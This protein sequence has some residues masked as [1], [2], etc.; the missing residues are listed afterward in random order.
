MNVKSLFSK[1]LFVLLIVIGLFS[2][3]GTSVFALDIGGNDENDLEYTILKWRRTQDANYNPE[4]FYNKDILCS[5]STMSSNVIDDTMDGVTADALKCNSEDP[6]IHKYPV[7]KMLDRAQPYVHPDHVNEKHSSFSMI[8][9]LFNVPGRESAGWKEYTGQDVRD[10]S[11]KLC[12]RDKNKKVVYSNCADCTPGDGVVDQWDAVTEGYTSGDIKYA[13]VYLHRMSKGFD[14]Y[15]NFRTDEVYDGSGSTNLDNVKK[16]SMAYYLTDN[17]GAFRVTNTILYY[18][19]VPHVLGSEGSKTMIMAI[20]DEGTGRPV[21]VKADNNMTGFSSVRTS[22][23][24][25]YTEDEIAG[26]LQGTDKDG[27]RYFPYYGDDL[28][29]DYTTIKDTMSTSWYKYHGFSYY[30]SE[31]GTTKSTAI[32]T[33]AGLHAA[34]TAAGGPQY[35]G[36]VEIALNEAITQRNSAYAFMSSYGTNGG[37]YHT[38]W[39]NTHGNNLYPETTR[40]QYWLSP[41]GTYYYLNGNTSGSESSINIIK[42]RMRSNI[43]D[44]AYWN[45]GLSGNVNPNG[46]NRNFKHSFGTFTRGACYSIDGKNC[47]SR[48]MFNY[49]ND[50]ELHVKNINGKSYFVYELVPKTATCDTVSG[51]TKYKK[52][53]ST[54]K[55]GQK[56]YCTLK[57]NNGISTFY[58]SEGLDSKSLT[59]SD[60]QVAHESG[61]YS[62]TEYTFSKI[63]IDKNVANKGKFQYS[64]AGN[65]WG[66][67][68]Q[69]GWSLSGVEMGGGFAP[70]TRPFPQSPDEVQTDYSDF[71]NM[72]RFA[73]SEGYYYNNES[74][75]NLGYIDTYIAKSNGTE[76]RYNQYEELTDMYLTIIRTFPDMIFRTFEFADHVKKGTNNCTAAYP[77]PNAGSGSGAEEE[78]IEEYIKFRAPK[79]DYDKIAAKL[80]DNLELNCNSVATFKTA[81]KNASGDTLKSDLFANGYLAIVDALRTKDSGN[82]TYAE[83]MAYAFYNFYVVI[84]MPDEYSVGMIFA[85]RNN[86]RNYNF[87]DVLLGDKSNIIMLNEET[88]LGTSAT[89]NV[90]SKGNSVGTNLSSLGSETGGFMTLGEKFGPELYLIN[91]TTGEVYIPEMD[92]ESMTCPTGYI[93]EDN[94]CKAIHVV[95][96]NR[97][98][99]SGYVFDFNEFKCVE[100]G[101]GVTHCPDGFELEGNVCVSYDGSNAIC[102]DGY[103]DAEKKVCLEY[104]D[105][106]CGGGYTLTDVTEAN[107]L[108]AN[109]TYSFARGN[110]DFG[111]FTASGVSNFRQ[112]S[113][114][115]IAYDLN[116]GDGYI[117]LTG[118]NL[119]PLKNNLIQIKMKN[120]SISDTAK[121]Y[122]TT[123]NSTGY[124]EAKSVSFEIEPN[125]DVT[126]YIYTVDMSGGMWNSNIKSLRFY[127]ADV[128]KGTITIDNI[129]I[130]NEAA[131]YKPTYKC[132]KDL[133]PVCPTGFTLYKGRCYGYA[134]D[135]TSLPDS[136][137]LDCSHIVP[138]DNE[139]VTL[140]SFRVGDYVNFEH[141][142]STSVFTVP[143]DGK[144]YIELWGA[145]NGTGKGGYTAGMADLKEGD[146]VYIHTATQNSARG[147]TAYKNGFG[148]DNILATAVSS[149]AGTNNLSSVTGINKITLS[150]NDWFK[151]TNNIGNTSWA[152]EQGHTG[153]GY[154][155]I[156]LYSAGGLTAQSGSKTGSVTTTETYNYTGASVTK[157]LLA[158]TYTVEVWGAQGGPSRSA[159]GGLGGYATGTLKLTSNSNLEILVGGMGA[160]KQQTS[161]YSSTGNAGGWP[162]GGKG[163]NDTDGNDNGNNELGGG[164]G[165]Y[166]TIRVNGTAVITGGGGGGKTYTYNPGGR[167]TGGAGGGSYYSTGA[168]GTLADSGGTAIGGVEAQSSTTN[169]ATGWYNTSYI[170]GGSVQ[171]A[172]KSGNG[173]IKITGTATATLGYYILQNEGSKELGVCLVH[174][175]DVSLGNKSGLELYV[176]SGYINKCGAEATCEEITRTERVNINKTFSYTGKM[177]KITLEPGTYTLEVWGAQGG[178]LNQSGSQTTSS[179]KGGY[180][181]ATMTITQDTVLYVGVGGQGKGNGGGLAAGGWNGGGDAYGSQTGEPGNGGGGATDIA[182]GHTAQAGKN[183]GAPGLYNGATASGTKWTLPASGRVH[184]HT[185]YNGLP[186][187]AYGNIW[188][189]DITGTGLSGMTSGVSFYNGSSWVSGNGSFIKIVRS[190]TSVQMFYR[191]LENWDKIG[192]TITNGGSGTA[193]IDSVDFVNLSNRIVVAGGGG[194]MGE[195][196]EAG[197]YGGG[198]SGGSAGSS[199]GTQSSGYMLGVGG[200]CHNGGA[201]GGGYYGGNTPYNAY[202]AS[203]NDC[204]GG[205]G[206]SGWVNTAYAVGSTYAGNTSFVAPGGGNETGH[207]G[208]GYARITGYHTK[209]VVYEVCSDGTITD[210]GE[211]DD[212]GNNAPTIINPPV[213][214]FSYTGAAQKV[215][216]APGTYKLETWGAQG[217]TGY[218]NS[219][220]GKGGYSVGTITLTENTDVFVYVG[221]NPGSAVTGGWNGGG[222]GNQ[223]R[224]DN[225]GGGGGTDIRIGSTSLYSRVIVAGGGGGGC[226]AGSTGY[227]GGATAGG[228]YP[229]GQTSAGSGG[230]FGQGANILA[231]SPYPTGGAGGGWYGGGGLTNG[232][233]SYSGNGGGSG[234]VYTASTAGSYPSGCTLNSSYYLSSA[235]TYAGNTSFV[236]PTGG[237]E[238]GH[239]GNGYARITTISGGSNIGGGINNQQVNDFYYTGYGQ[240]ITLK[241]GTYQLETWGARGGQGADGTTSYTSWNFGKGGYSSGVI[242]FDT[243]TTLYVYVGGM[244]QGNNGSYHSSGLVSGGFNGGGNAYHDGGEFG[245]SGGGATHIATKDGLLSSL[246]NSRDSILV[247]AGGGGGSGEDNEAAGHGGGYTSVGGY[248][249]NY[250]ASQS[251]A[252]TRG[253]FGQGAH[254]NSTGESGGGGG[255]GYYGGG[256]GEGGG[257]GGGSGYVGNQLTNK[258]S[259]AGDTSFVAP[260]GGY[261]TG[262]SDHGFARI[263]NLGYNDVLLGGLSDNITYQTT[264]GPLNATDFSVSRNITTNTGWWAGDVLIGQNYL[265]LMHS[266]MQYIMVYT[267]NPDGTIGSYVGTT[268]WYNNDSYIQYISTSS[269]PTAYTTYYKDGVTKLVGWSRSHSAIFEWTINE[270]NHTISGRTQYNTDRAFGNYG[271]AA[272][273]GENTVYFVDGRGNGSS[274]YLYKFNVSTKAITYIGTLS[275]ANYSYSS[276]TGGAAYIDKVNNHIYLS[277][278]TDCGCGHSLV[279]YDLANGKWVKTITMSEMHNAGLRVNGGAYSNIAIMI[280]PT[281]PTVGWAMSSNYAGVT[282]LY[283]RNNNVAT[284]TP[285]YIEESSTSYSYKGK[286]EEVTLDPGS[287]KLEVWGAQGGQGYSNSSYVGIGGKGGYAAGFLTLTERTTLYLYVGGMGASDNGSC[288]YPAGGWNGGGNAYCYSGGGGGATDIRMGGTGLG[289]RIIVAGGGGGGHAVNSYISHGGYGGGYQG[290]QSNAHA[291]WSTSY[292]STGGTQ[293]GG[294]T[295]NSGWAVGGSWGQGGSYYSSYTGGG[296]GGYYGGAAGGYH[297]TGGAGGSGYVGGVINGYM[298]DGSVSFTG[299]DG[300]YENGHSGNGAI[301]ITKIKSV[302]ANS[303]VCSMEARLKIIPTCTNGIAFDV[304]TNKC[305]LQENIMCAVGTVYNEDM[306]KCEA[307]VAPVSCTNDGIVYKIGNEYF[308]K[309]EAASWCD[310]GYHLVNGVCVKEELDSYQND[311]CAPP[312]NF[313]TDGGN[314]RCEYIEVRDIT[315]FNEISLEG[316]M[317]NV[318]VG[319]I[320]KYTN[321]VGFK[322][323]SSR[324]AKYVDAGLKF[325]NTALFPTVNIEFTLVA[326]TGTAKAA[327]PSKFASTEQCRICKPGSVGDV[328][329]CANVNYERDCGVLNGDT[330]QTYKIVIPATDIGGNV[331][332]GG[333]ESVFAGNRQYYN[334]RSYMTSTTPDT[335]MFLNTSDGDQVNAS[336]FLWSMWQGMDKGFILDSDFSTMWSEIDFYFQFNE[337]S[338]CYYNAPS[339]EEVAFGTKKTCVPYSF[340]AGQ[341]K[342][343]TVEDG[344]NKLNMEEDEN[345]ETYVKNIFISSVIGAPNSFV[346][347]EFSEISKNKVSLADA[348]MDNTKFTDDRSDFI[349]GFKLA[350]DGDVY[351]DRFEVLN[352]TTLEVVFAA[353]ARTLDRCINGDELRKGSTA[354]YTTSTT[355]DPVHGGYQLPYDNGVARAEKDKVYCNTYDPVSQTHNLDTNVNYIVK[356]YTKYEHIKESNIAGNT[357][358]SMSYISVDIQ[359]L[360]NSAS[361][362]VFNRIIPSMENASV[363]EKMTIR[364]GVKSPDGTCAA[365]RHKSVVNVS[366]M[367]M[368]QGKPEENKCVVSTAATD[369]IQRFYFSTNNYMLTVSEPNAAA[370]IPANGL[371][372]KSVRNGS[373]NATISGEAATINAYATWDNFTFNYSLGPG[374]NVETTLIMRCYEIGSNTTTVDFITRDGACVIIDTDKYDRCSLFAKIENIEN[375]DVPISTN[376]RVVTDTDVNKVLD[377]NQGDLYNADGSNRF[378][379]TNAATYGGH[380]T[381]KGTGGAN[382]TGHAGHGYARITNIDTGSVVK[383]FS[384]TGDVQNM[385]L[386]AGNYK[387][388][389]WGAQGGSKWGT[390]GKG[391]YSV[392]NLTINRTVDIAVYV[393]G[394]PADNSLTGGWNGGGNG[395]E[396][397]SVQ[398]YRSPGGGATDI[399][400]NGTAWTD[401]IIVAGGGGGG[402]KYAVDQRGGPG[403]GSTAHFNYYSTWGNKQEFQSQNYGASQTES[404]RASVDSYGY[405]VTCSA[406]SLGQGAGGCG[407]GYYGGG[408]YSCANRV[409]SGSGGSGYVRISTTQ[410]KLTAD[411]PEAEVLIKANVEGSI[412]AIATHNSADNDGYADVD[413][414]NNTDANCWVVGNYTNYSIRNLNVD[415]FKIWVDTDSNGVLANSGNVTV[416]F[417]GTYELVKERDTDKV[418]PNKNLDIKYVLKDANGNPVTGSDKCTFTPIAHVMNVGTGGKVLITFNGTCNLQFKKSDIENMMSFTVMINGGKTGA[419]KFTEAVYDDN[420]DMVSVP[421]DDKCVGEDCMPVCDDLI[422]TRRNTWGVNF[423][424]LY[425]FDRN[426]IP[427]QTSQQANLSWIDY[428]VG[429]VSGSTQDREYH[430]TIGTGNVNRAPDDYMAFKSDKLDYTELCTD[431]KSNSKACWRY[432]MNVSHN[433]TYYLWSEAKTSVYTTHEVLTSQGVAGKC[434]PQNSTFVNGS[435]TYGD[436]NHG[437]S[438][439]NH[440]FADSTE[441]DR[442]VNVCHGYTEAPNTTKCDVVTDWW[443]NEICETWVETF[444]PDADSGLKP[445]DYIPY[446]YFQDYTLE[447]GAGMS[448]TTKTDHIVMKNQTQTNLNQGAAHNGWAQTKTMDV[449]DVMS[450]RDVSYSCETY[451]VYGTDANGRSFAQTTKNGSGVC[452]AADSSDNTRT[453]VWENETMSPPEEV[454][455]NDSGATCYRKHAD[456]DCLDYFG[457]ADSGWVQNSGNET[458]GSCQWWQTGTITV[459]DSGITDDTCHHMNYSNCTGEINSCV[460]CDEYYNGSCIAESPK[461]HSHTGSCEYH[462]WTDGD[463]VDWTLTWT[464]GHSESHSDSKDCGGAS[465]STY[466]RYHNES[467]TPYNVA[468]HMTKRCGSGEIAN[469]DVYCYEYYN[470]SVSLELGTP[471][472]VRWRTEEYQEIKYYTTNSGDSGNSWVS[473]THSNPTEIWQYTCDTTEPKVAYP[474]D[475]VIMKSYSEEIVATSWIK[476]VSSGDKWIQLNFEGDTPPEARPRSGEWF[477]LKFVTTYT[478]DRATRPGAAPRTDRPF[479]LDFYNNYHNILG[480]LGEDNAT[481]YPPTGYNHFGVND[482]GKTAIGDGKT[483]TPNSFSDVI[484]NED[485]GYCDVRPAEPYGCSYQAGTNQ[486]MYPN[487]NNSTTT[488]GHVGAEWTTNQEGNGVC[489]YGPDNK[490]V[491]QKFEF[492]NDYYTGLIIC[493]GDKDTKRCEI[494]NALAT[495]W[496]VESS[497]KCMNVI[498]GLC[499]QWQIE[500]VTPVRKDATGNQR[501]GFYLEKGWDTTKNLV[502]DLRGSK[503]NAVGQYEKELLGENLL[504]SR[505]NDSFFEEVGKPVIPL[506]VC[507]TT[508]TMG[509][510]NDY[511]WGSTEWEVE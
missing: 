3:L 435:E 202:S 20:M 249:T 372:N 63:N 305:T 332:N 307:Q 235:Q 29:G 474:N 283:I 75:Y 505:N 115:T 92:L 152:G 111:K 353:E 355:L 185:G 212:G 258:V 486:F 23:K 18:N 470:D 113:D 184:L 504:A 41:R 118:L 6:T 333:L 14:L 82:I 330:Y 150:G 228:S 230:S 12:W 54:T 242:T 416:N 131:D 91:E 303:G 279:V 162:G 294:G 200:S 24:T 238:T 410:N 373:Y 423:D 262:H 246:G 171:T 55:T 79:A 379:L 503:F 281:H 448:P 502:F 254:Y 143:V 22:L 300:T 354:K 293:V 397:P 446:A 142:T 98:C 385:K 309:R 401:R 84:S 441:T 290:G 147:T 483:M 176:N 87:E 264:N 183:L 196:D 348:Y 336:E 345:G 224:S 119:D 73:W 436:N 457:W 496:L 226:H 356:I 39:G 484:N 275:G 449:C 253:S 46:I 482:T 169:A 480:G 153:N 223:N 511:K 442:S 40:G 420:E 180:T 78:K 222:S 357:P 146:T 158:G 479:L 252:G 485:Y 181:T 197:G 287:Y 277:E 155:R 340:T 455:W 302:T 274:E 195:D 33:Q 454:W 388:E 396:A 177:Q 250:N 394:H 286:Y 88:R 234:Y 49:F 112:D 419:H 366:A 239:A 7:W 417:T 467:S 422:C 208:N 144:Y 193:V 338:F 427:Y 27:N 393:G 367:S 140:A 292:Y 433:V 389:V 299:V 268:N 407:G 315:D 289:N 319:K 182:I 43:T 132:V 10:G 412:Q 493:T 2:I 481:T 498:D 251:A 408:Y 329:T 210:K 466:T 365:I 221:G 323:T 375:K 308:C 28:N 38:A 206:G 273:D 168:A 240:S 434:T 351:I 358:A 16:S 213:M 438:G 207:A 227:G 174:A 383:S 127:L 50:V 117:E 282:E 60:R 53:D 164:G 369:A 90:D 48:V 284:I 362:S 77:G 463:Y 409:Y 392:G 451:F 429:T 47:Y 216:L 66:V 426:I 387:L 80:C 339:N 431:Y 270:S 314:P 477:D 161:F 269:T 272:W 136:Y 188:R 70:D 263:T 145:S 456:W 458:S 391:G 247:V 156:T 324:G 359:H 364:G 310:M 232:A 133:D 194:G 245:G 285:T 461:C 360:E 510:P 103:W 316:E 94:K 471:R 62:T 109:L 44:E 95:S 45:L 334:S 58:Y 21:P 399:R 413:W 203:E 506:C 165:G 276:Y 96:Y 472:C 128:N 137:E 124:N 233:S 198:T 414:T 261:E 151:A 444:S 86:G 163:G 30:Y 304:N 311:L 317:N 450:H 460:S 13:M 318:E 72:C 296:G 175:K 380:E 141:G 108:A 81:S 335:S 440:N 231:A 415:P 110:G 322:T 64:N 267:R 500:W 135:L 260:Y 464:D 148:Y 352:A 229:G 361:D 313:V 405:T 320:Y 36:T 403:G 138:K 32:D 31:K 424:F 350:P 452:Y 381:F 67:W 1:W 499:V 453:C 248:N 34:I 85:S 236:S 215:T 5:S 204:Q 190:D 363:S 56:P 259:L 65:A 178:T 205:S 337:D 59:Y 173:Q 331:I 218:S 167:G 189:I 139:T 19:T 266:N 312:Y 121:I 9:Y 256:G 328:D 306:A 398:V 462:W 93:R 191:S 244:G 15:Q 298:F 214:D 209:N 370:I 301:K 488:Q 384:Y 83:H 125:S 400:I 395:G 243:E 101:S 97:S 437:A 327:S 374:P 17:N 123:A 489:Y 418:N 257:S 321:Y 106:F 430:T 61:D 377:V 100:T 42:I 406:G 508:K 411:Q 271:R 342:F 211:I 255:G 494:E 116:S 473:R 192:F 154:A 11:G 509:D 404:C 104:S 129:A 68:R 199:A 126:Y 265:Y 69:T 130:G 291:N 402:A 25:K 347:P 346:D 491:W 297:G 57:E 134:S 225:G 368:L 497:S 371:K 4:H 326:P 475:K 487:E 37:N 443:G 425:T 201:A 71:S 507:Q 170:T 280:D 8:T 343:I 217:G 237:N 447:D 439:E 159:A 445:N 495:A 186:G 421:V 219:A 492:G 122:Y 341:E 52:Y 349:S 278:A 172:K 325:A 114:S 432:E 149:A 76:A 468:E 478:T 74:V 179:G 160:G 476:T 382:E 220:G 469:D 107:K 89:G 501:N 386:T 465:T 35:I 390:G 157:S 51:T 459:T 378:F 295:T 428:D 102:E 166:S 344:V 120:A 490:T 376:I 288:N 241:P 187:S 26:I 105:A 99:N